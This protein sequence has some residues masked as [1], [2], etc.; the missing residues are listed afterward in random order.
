MFILH[1]GKFPLHEQF[2]FCIIKITMSD[3]A[4]ANP[5]CCM[6]AMNF[7]ASKKLN[8]FK[9]FSFLIRILSCKTALPVYC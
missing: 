9:K 7:T 3:Y 5:A 6:T 2:G 8:F 1:S 4:A